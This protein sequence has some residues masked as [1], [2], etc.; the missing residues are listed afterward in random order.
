MK[1]AN[2]HLLQL[3]LLACVASA[4]AQVID[5]TLPDSSAIPVIEGYYYQWGDEF[6]YEGEPD[7]ELWAPESGFVRGEEAQYYQLKNA[8]VTGGRLLIQGKKERVRN[9]NYDSSSSDWRKN[10]QYG[11]YTSAS[12][13]GKNKRHFLYGHIEVRAKLDISN[14]AFPAIWTCGINKDWP[15]NGEIDIMEY[16]KTGSNYVLTSNF[17]VGGD[18]NGN[19][20]YWAQKWQSVFTNRNYYLAKDADWFS[21]YHLFTMDWDESTI[22]IGVDGESRNVLNINNFKNWD[23]SICFNNPQFMMLNLAIKDFGDGIADSLR[24]EVDYYRVY[25]KIEDSEKPSKVTGLKVLNVSDCEVTLSWNS[26]TDDTG[27]LRYDIYRNGSSDGYFKGSTTDTV[28][29]VSGLAANS[30]QY[31]VVRAL[32][33]V[34]NHSDTVRLYVK[35]LAAVVI[36][37]NQ[38]AEGDYYLLRKG[39]SLYWTN[40]LV[41]GSSPV[42]AEK[43]DDDDLTQ[44]WTI[45]LDNGYYKLVNKS[46]GRYI[47]ENA[48]FGTN[49][50]YANWNS[51]NIYSDDDLNCGFQVTQTAATGSDWSL[52]GTYFWKWNSDNLV[53]VDKTHTDI[54]GSSD[55]I[56]TF[57]PCLV[58]GIHK[59]FVEKKNNNLIYTLSGIRVPSMNHA[60]VYIVNGKKIV[61]N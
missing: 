11:E 39:T 49:A 15:Q 8:T 33:H 48:R 4:Q 23:G 37:K 13:L 60:G 27:V 40:T 3:W 32:D 9:A 30:N 46:D 45:S 31:F 59:N 42:L 36:N 2:K 28:F 54:S 25:Q 61:F 41:S 18:Q 14:G 43:K 24:F 1:I 16:Y 44:V 6:N 51:Y 20:G 19:D 29:T 10:R 21:K 22:T 26:S 53:E 55:L 52:G 5:P 7:T 50:Y 57:V 35:T 12:L 38:I 56:F 47:N 34:G 58:D 17:C